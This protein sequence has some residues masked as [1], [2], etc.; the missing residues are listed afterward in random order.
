[1]DHRRMPFCANS[2]ADASST[3]EDADAEDEAEVGNVAQSVLRSTGKPS[4]SRRTKR[5]TER[6]MTKR[7]NSG[8]GE[9]WRKR[10]ARL[11]EDDCLRVFAV[12]GCGNWSRGGIAAPNPALLF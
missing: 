11:V 1:M 12:D 2:W 9:K 4:V 6:E 7:T 8:D 3:S 5:K 10:K